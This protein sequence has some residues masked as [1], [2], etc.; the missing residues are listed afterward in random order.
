M[1]DL[2]FEPSPAVKRAMAHILTWRKSELYS[3]DQ[4]LLVRYRDEVLSE[5]IVRLAM[6]GH[7]APRGANPDDAPRHKD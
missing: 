1:R 5:A 2:P 3:S 4:Q 7:H 6:N